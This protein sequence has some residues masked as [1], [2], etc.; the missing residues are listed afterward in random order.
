VAK[1]PMGKTRDVNKPYAVFRLGLL[2]IRVLKTYQLPKNE[3]KNMF[4]RWFTAA[5][6]PMT[7]DRWE[8]G[9]TYKREVV[10]SF[11][12]VASSPEYDQAYGK[13]GKPIDLT[14]TSK[15]GNI[16]A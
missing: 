11:E 8:Y 1:N 9:D 12:Q 6:S 10:D 4:A 7:Y 16:L 5:K 2:E 3:E 14:P 13:D 15:H